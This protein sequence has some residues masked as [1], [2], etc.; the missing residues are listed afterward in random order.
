ME[1][2]VVRS[3]SLYGSTADCCAGTAIDEPWLDNAPASDPE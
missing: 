2:R 1:R 3:E